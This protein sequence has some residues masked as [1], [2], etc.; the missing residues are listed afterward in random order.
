MVTEKTYKLKEGVTLTEFDENDGVESYLIRYR[1]RLW[2]GSPIVYY[3]ASTILKEEKTK[4]QIREELGK[5]GKDCEGTDIES[6]DPVLLFFEENHMMEGTGEET[7][8]DGVRA[9]WL[10]FTIFPAGLV[11][12]F[13][14]GFHAFFYRTPFYVMTALG[15]LTYICI[16]L[17]NPPSNLSEEI[18]KMSPNDLIQVFLLTFF[19]TFC[20]E[21]GHVSALMHF[22]KEAG[23]IG[24]GLYYIMP[25]AYSNVENSW[26]LKRKE[27][28]IVDFGGIYFQMIIMTVLMAV[29]TFLLRS[30]IVLISC[31]A[32]ASTVMTNFSP[33]L[34]FD[35]YW[36]A[37]DAFGVT[38]V[39]QAF[40]E[41]VSGKRRMKPVKKVLF[42]LYYIA[43]SLLLVYFIAMFASMIGQSIWVFYGDMVTLIHYPQ[44]LTF[45]VQ[46]ISH[47]LRSR[48]TYAVSFIFGVRLLISGVRRVVLYL[49]KEWKKPDG[50]R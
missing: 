18:L 8:S 32:S 48:I 1:N 29:N 9:M 46:S 7:E 15:F 27:R 6:I 21:I 5:G 16:M 20:H 35:G 31:I 33:V 39:K 12:R 13:L 49:L 44:K 17:T 50:V 28:I 30:D 26:E 43:S 4:S 14:K 11:N 40:Q 41:L 3:V 47:Y 2:Q 22:G 42:Y 23:E 19:Q 36:I 25:V 38:D 24:V 37:C 34:R 10:K 45:T